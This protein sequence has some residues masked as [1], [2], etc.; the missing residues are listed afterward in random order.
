VQ[1]LF[2]FLK[3]FSEFG[4]FLNQQ[5]YPSGK[6]LT[7]FRGVWYRIHMTHQF[8]IAHLFVVSHDIPLFFVQTCKRL[9]KSLNPAIVLQFVYQ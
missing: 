5:L 1:F 2:G 4:G 3:L 9:T 7:Q 6:R 8:Q